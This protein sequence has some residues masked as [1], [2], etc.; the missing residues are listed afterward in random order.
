M[1]DLTSTLDTALNK[2]VPIDS[3]LKYSTTFIAW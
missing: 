2:A 1:Y 3:M